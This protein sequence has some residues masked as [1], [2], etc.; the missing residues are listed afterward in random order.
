MPLGTEVGLGPEDIVLHGDPALPLQK[1]GGS[2]LP[3]LLPMSVV[4]K[5]LDGSRW[6]GG[7]PWSWP[8]CARWGPSSLPSPE[9]GA[10]PCPILGPFLL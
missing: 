3:N 7:A 8:H 2:P 5:L 10:E 9:K 1:G 6:N 4:A